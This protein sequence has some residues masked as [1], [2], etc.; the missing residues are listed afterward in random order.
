MSVSLGMALGVAGG[1]VLEVPAPAALVV[2]VA[3]GAVVLLVVLAAVDAFG[4]ALGLDWLL[5]A[6]VLLP[7]P[8]ITKM[9][10]NKAQTTASIL[11]LHRLVIFTIRFPNILF[12]LQSSWSVKRSAFFSRKPCLN[13]H[14]SGGFG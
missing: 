13:R 1:V 4:D 12:W 7:H 9:T 11:A 14:D 5:V 2:V 6:A 3:L 10:N 8:L